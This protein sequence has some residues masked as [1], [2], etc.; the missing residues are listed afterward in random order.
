MYEH[1]MCVKNHRAVASA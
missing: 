1:F